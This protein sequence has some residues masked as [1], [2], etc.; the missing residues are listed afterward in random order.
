V[1]KQLKPGDVLGRYQLLLPVAKGGMGQVWAARLTGTRGFQKLVAVKTILCPSDDSGGELETMLFEEA[2]LASQIRHPNVAQTL[3]LGEQDGALYLVMEWVDGEPLDFVMRTARAVGGVPIAIAVHLIVQACKGLQAAHEAKD[4][5]GEPLGIVH[6]DISPQNLLVSYSGVVKL[7]DFGVAKATH[8]MSQPTAL[9]TVK[10]KFA[11]MSPEQVQ[12]EALD[13][14]SDIFGMGI[15]LYRLTTGK[16]PFKAD[17]SA[18]T[19]RN[20]LTKDAALPSELGQPYPATLEAVVKKALARDKADRFASA[21]EM[22][23][24]LERALPPRVS[25]HADKNTEVFLNRL[26]QKRIT[27]RNEALQL[28]LKAAD[29]ESGAMVAGGLGMHLPRSQST[30]RGVSL[31]SSASPS[32]SESSGSKVVVLL[33]PAKR[34]RRWP[35]FALAASALVGLGVGI[36]REVHPVASGAGASV[37]PVGAAL[38]MTK[39]ALTLPPAFYPEQQPQRDETG[40]GTANATPLAPDAAAPGTGAWNGGPSNAP[41]RR[42]RGSRREGPPSA[43][44]A[45][46]EARPSPPAM[47]APSD[48]DPLNRRK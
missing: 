9:G 16:H 41:K 46:S 23:V 18:A 12:G 3:D 29:R 48:V 10:G 14:R 34:R 13:G 19:I 7:V 45:A 28:A 2:S 4:S 30:M 47:G 25:D 33:E 44:E 22:M 32:V 39:P 43:A 40:A 27:E 5:K 35:M 20:I 11:Y 31:E 26:F 36:L 6:R 38:P 8:Q 1:A 17:N 37:G 21:H 24:A 15:V 42:E